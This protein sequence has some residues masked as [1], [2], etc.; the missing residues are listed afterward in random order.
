MLAV[1]GTIYVHFP[2]PNLVEIETKITNNDD[3]STIHSLTD[4]NIVPQSLIPNPKSFCHTDDYVVIKY[5]NSYFPGEI[6]A[7]LD[8]FALVK[9]MSQSAPQYWKWLIEMMLFCINGVIS[10]YISSGR[11]G[12]YLA[13]VYVTITYIGPW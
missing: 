6:I 5:N 1:R 3:K 2:A 13:D 10:R 4:S 12:I 9:V 11:N 8:E 7:I